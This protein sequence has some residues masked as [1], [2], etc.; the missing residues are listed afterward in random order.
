MFD[1]PEDDI[2]CHPAEATGGEI[3]FYT[4]DIESTVA[5]LKA[6]G[7]ETPPIRE[8]DWGRVTS[9]DVPGAG[10]VG[11][12]SAEVREGVGS[13]RACAYARHVLRLPHPNS[14]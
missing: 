9:I 8:E 5:E 12:L 6:K 4:D 14:R 7:V 11:P 10:L 3:S 1:L 2:G 13:H